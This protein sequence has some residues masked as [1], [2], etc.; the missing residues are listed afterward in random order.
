[1]SSDERI[2]E[3]GS[4]ARIL[5]NIRE[6]FAQT[7][8]SLPGYLSTNE[9]DELTSAQ[10]EFVE[11]HREL[12]ISR[13]LSGKVRD[14]HG[15]LRLEHVYFGWDSSP[16]IIDCIEFNER[17]RFADVCADIAFLGMDFAQHGRM[18]MGEL[19]VAEY[20][21]IS[22]DYELYRLI[23]F[24]E[25]Y[26][27]FIR[28][29]VS[30]MLESDV[31]APVEVRRRAHEAARRYYRLALSS[32]RPSL[33]QAAVV[34][35]GGYIASGKSTWAEKLGELM[36]APLVESDRTRKQLLSVPE[37]RHLDEPAW[38][39]AYAPAMTERVYA[40]LFARAQSVLASG[41]S[42]V[43]DASFRTREL[44][45]RARRLARAF[46]VPFHFVECRATEEDCRKRLRARAAAGGLSDA[47]EHLFEDFRRRWEVVDELPPDEHI[48][49]H[50]SGELDT[51]LQKLERLLPT[52]PHG[53]VQ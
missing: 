15:D 19:F 41:R 22:G 49:L 7:E 12:F 40:E 31:S 48:V 10:I 4:P 43:L 28:G 53:L 20:A 2:S 24:Y 6:N 29:K 50:T 42:V 5:H 17:F 11:Q 52:W 21:R 25:G 47:R 30:S 44:R 16:T 1:M 51:N 14:G 46:A 3:F 35:V 26:R 34:A 37:S 9:A 33:M 32:N 13:M 8:D 23:D 18:D 38:S 36:S 45:G 27:A 39:G